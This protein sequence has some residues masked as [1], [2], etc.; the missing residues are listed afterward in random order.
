MRIE[1]YHRGDV[2]FADLGSLDLGELYYHSGGSERCRLHPFGDD[3][4]RPADITAE[5][6]GTAGTLHS[7]RGG[8][9]EE[10]IHGAGRG[11]RHH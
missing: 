9:P 10:E 2:F 11:N 3:H 7:G 4:G 1:E 8:F 6:A 5:A